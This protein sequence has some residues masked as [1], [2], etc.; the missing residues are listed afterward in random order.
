VESGNRRWL[1][2]PIRRGQAAGTPGDDDVHLSP[3]GKWLAFRRRNAS[4][5]GDAFI[6]PVSGGAA[7]ALT[8]DQTGLNGLAWTRDGQSLIVSSQRQSG[9][10]RLWRFPLNGRTPVCLTDAALSAS[11]PAVSPRDGQIAFASRY[12]NANIWRIDLQ[13]AAPEQVVAASN[14]LDSS[15]RYSPQ[16][17]R[18]AFRNRTGSDEIWS[19][20]AGGRFAVRLTSIGGPVTGSPRWSPDGQYLAFD[21]RPN[22]SA[23][24]LVIPAGGGRPRNLTTE[25]S[26]EVTPAFSADGKSIYF[27]SDRTGTW[28]VWKQPLDGGAARQITSAGG[29]APQETADGQWLYYAKLNTGG[30]FRVPVTGGA[31]S[32]VLESPPGSWGSW[33]V[34]GSRVIYATLPGDH[35]AA[36]AELRM[37]NPKSGETRTLARLQ[38]PPLQWDGSIAVSPDGRY[39][40]VA[41]V[42][43]QGSEIHLQPER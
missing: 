23:D 36:V 7:R 13:G 12:F 1:L 16:G 33:A 39:A 42:E 22:G 20:D 29:F 24:I 8:H 11:F 10:V 27:A 35:D 37:L 2:T 28:Q 6:A 43:R 4:V 25:A 26:N 40:L 32:V 31:E 41:E 18:I 19:A 5:V 17:D 3:D 21:S 38:H 30:V 15:P 9:L 34:A 14:L